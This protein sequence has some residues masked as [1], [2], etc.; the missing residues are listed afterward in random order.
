[1]LAL[2]ALPAPLL[3]LGE[4]APAAAQRRIVGGWSTTTRDHPWMVALSS[5]EQFGSARS[6]Q[7]CGGALVSPTKVVTAAHCF[8]NESTGRRTDRPGLRVIIGRDDLNSRDGREVAVRE[9]WV[10]QGYSFATNERDIAVVTLAEP[11]AGRESLQ[12]VGQGESEPYRAGTAAQV[13]GWGDTTGGGRYSPTLREVE[14]PLIADTDCSHA[15]PPGG[16]SPFD[17]R[18]MVC[19]AAPKGGRDACQGDSG[20]P[21]LVAG[22]LVGLVSWG[23]GCAEAAHPGVYTRI[24]AV[25]D[26]MRTVLD[27]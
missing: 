1:M 26:D 18:T 8:F 2:A 9:V 3:T 12:V 24:A 10:D 5:R 16:D 15:Y 19:A 14:V 11:Q 23:T 13:Y 7:F 22:R 17:A 27:R 25:A 20:G 6:G 4:A 21:L